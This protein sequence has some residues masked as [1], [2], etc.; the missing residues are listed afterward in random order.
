[1]PVRYSGFD[2]DGCVG[3]TNLINIVA[4]NPKLVQ[5]IR[6]TSNY[7]TKEVA[8]IASN[9]QSDRDDKR[10]ARSNGNG[11]CFIQIQK[12]CTDLGMEFDPF[13]LAD[14]YNLVP[15]GTS[16]HEATNPANGAK[17]Q[18]GWLHD[19]SKTSL[20]YAHMQRAS[21]LEAREQI[22]YFFYDDREDILEGLYQF[23]SANPELI[24][25]NVTMHLVKYACS[26]ENVHTMDNYKIPVQGKGFTNP[27]YV[28]TIKA[29]GDKA[30]ENARDVY[31]I[32]GKEINAAGVRQAKYNCNFEFEVN[33]LQ[34]MKFVNNFN[35]P[36]ELIKAH[37]QAIEKIKLDAFELYKA[38]INVITTL[39]NEQKVFLIRA[40]AQQWN[41]LCDEGQWNNPIFTLQAIMAEKSDRFFLSQYAFT[42][43]ML[44]KNYQEAR[45]N[46]KDGSRFWEKI[47]AF[48]KSM[49]ALK[50]PMRNAQSIFEVFKKNSYSVK[51]VDGFVKKVVEVMN[52][53]MDK[54]PQRSTTEMVAC[55]R[56]LESNLQKMVNFFSL[57]DRLITIYR[58]C[59]TAGPNFNKIL[60]VVREAL[61]EMK[62]ITDSG[63]N[64]STTLIDLDKVITATNNRL[65]SLTYPKEYSTKNFHSQES[66]KVVGAYLCMQ[67][68]L[69]QKLDTKA[70]TAF[71]I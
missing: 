34:P 39:S 64:Y 62:M 63:D 55:M 66:Y 17:I 3:V 35:S 24:P 52:A 26:R 8:L 59:T 32:D 37:E 30:I 25:S 47:N 69:T 20:V 71:A 12:L 40:K 1:M 4:Q 48:I 65:E 46:R 58:G 28:K 45:E 21:S 50:D 18:N 10:N 61:E 42:A 43:K 31:D 9:R 56:I 19:K 5:R 49:N 36:A 7:Y 23:F 44:I 51:A 27:D 41:V 54:Y 13:L 57:V 11:S 14:A 16:L 53:L 2:Y 67:S 38:K 29:F 60:T 70:S 33:K 68:Q 22:D 15:A 6:E